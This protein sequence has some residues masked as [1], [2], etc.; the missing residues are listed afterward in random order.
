MMDK[1]Q[2]QSDDPVNEI[3]DMVQDLIKRGIPAGYYGMGRNLETGYGVEEDQ[4]LALRYYR[5]AAD[6]GGQYHVGDL[7]NDFSKHG[8]EIASIGLTMQRCAAEQGH[9]KAAN[10]VG[11]DV[12]QDGKLPEAMKYFQL[13][14]MAGS[15]Q[16]ADSLSEACGKVQGDPIYDLGQA[17][18][19]ERKARYKKVWEFLFDYSYLNP[20]V[21]ELDSIVPLP[22]AKLPTW[23]GKFKWLEAHEAN[24]PPPLPTEERIAEMAKAKGLD[25]K[26][27]R[28][29]GAKK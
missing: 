10:E 28:Q 19:P 13:A 5:K 27:G 4:E 25:P 22:P 15:D 17:P 2:A 16:A 9:A 11:I 24:V 8:R 18:D 12:R 21:P 20:Q 1:D 6:L 7:L 3:I 29:I 26:T 23:D 14:A